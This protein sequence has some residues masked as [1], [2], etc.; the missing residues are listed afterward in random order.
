MPARLSVEITDWVALRARTHPEHVAVEVSG[1]QLTYADLDRRVG[2]AAGALRTLGIGA[3]EPVAVLAGNGLEIA[4]FAH[5]IPRSGAMFMPLNARLS[6]EE[7]AY[8]LDDA[9]VR[10]LVATGEYT[11]AARTAAGAASRAVDVLLADDPRWDAGSADGGAEEIAADQP[12]SLIYTSGTT[13]RPKG[14][15]LTH[16]NFYWSAVAS[17]ANL[18]VREDDR[19]LACLPLF[20][21]G[22]LSI[23]LR[24]AIYGT[25]A[26][27]HERFDE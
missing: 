16:G 15:V 23:L 17:A 7:I 3:A 6:A 24:S 12:H 19:W 21:V 27:V 14:A 1:T 4:R 9:R 8:Q 25:T 10:F 5:A 20:H 26:V 13:G 22:G 18:G 2:T 11:E